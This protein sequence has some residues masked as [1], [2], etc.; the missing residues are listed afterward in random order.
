[1]KWLFRGEFVCDTHPFFFN[2]FD[3]QL[4]LL[5]YIMQREVTTSISDEAKKKKK[6][7]R[8]VGFRGGQKWEQTHARTHVWDPC[9]ANRRSV[10][11]DKHPARSVLL[12]SYS[13]VGALGAIF[14]FT[15][16]AYMPWVG[17]ELRDHQ[18]KETTHMLIILGGKLWALQRDTFC[19]RKPP[20]FSSISCPASTPPTIND[21][22][23]N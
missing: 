8:T 3:G 9:R 13:D 22:D 14:R 1:M 19:I 20:V 15:Y 18:K 5:K 2:Y 7:T 12:S 16:A 17:S 10:P 4:W 21:H 6:A 11:P 23:A